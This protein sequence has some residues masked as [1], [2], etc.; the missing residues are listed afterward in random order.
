MV[1]QLTLFHSKFSFIRISSFFLTFI[2]SKS[3]LVYSISCLAQLLLYIRALWSGLYNLYV[4]YIFSIHIAHM[5]SKL[6]NNENQFY[7]NIYKII[8]KRF[9]SNL[10][11]RKAQNLNLDGSFFYSKIIYLPSWISNTGLHTK[12]ENI[13]TTKNS[14]NMANL[15]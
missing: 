12:D 14:L 11:R 10:R 4:G 6:T 3:Y 5:L 1:I 13:K 2:R 7:S 9:Y 15:I 8:I